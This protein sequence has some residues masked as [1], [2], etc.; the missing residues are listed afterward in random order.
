MAVN[1]SSLKATLTTKYAGVP[2]YVYAAAGTA[3]LAWY[4]IKRHSRSLASKAAAQAGGDPTSA[5]NAATQIPNI[6]AGQVGGM[7]GL[8]WGYDSVYGNYNPPQQPSTMESGTPRPKHGTG[9]R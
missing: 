2:T 9:F 8:P 7:S 4:L 1:A 6:P 3:L 5:D